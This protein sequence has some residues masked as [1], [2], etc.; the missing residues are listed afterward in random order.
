MKYLTTIAGIVLLCCAHALGWP[1]DVETVKELDV[2]KYTG[3]WYEAYGSLIQ[4][5][6][7]QKDS[8]C[9]CATYG[10]RD[11]GKISVFNAGRLHSPTGKANNITGYAY[12]VDPKFPGKLKVV[13][14]NTGAPAGN[15]WVMK[16]GPLN[17]E[18]LYSYAVVTSNL[19][20]FLWI[21]V[22]DVDDYMKNH[23]AEIQKYVKEKGFTWF[24]N[25]PRKTYQ[26]KD[27]LYP[28]EN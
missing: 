27:C 6:T 13:F 9:T 14:P 17:K 11:D 28:K 25:K 20:S 23:D 19:K 18:G 15:Y 21:L 24:W 2:H 5:W 1:W 10:I 7:F 16:L 3:R 4:K 8:F 22:R 12:V 26:G